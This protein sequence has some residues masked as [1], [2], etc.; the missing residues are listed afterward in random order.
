[1]RYSYFP[2]CTLKTKGAELD[3]CGILAA[4]ALGVELEEIPDWQCCGGVYPLA[5]DEIAPRLSSVRALCAA[6][7]RGDRLVTLC[8][9]CYHVLKR[10]NRDMRIDP[11]I[12]QKVNCYLQ[13]PEPYTGQTEV[14]HYLEVLRGL[15][16][17]PGEGGQAS[18][19][20]KGRRLLR[21]SAAA[22]QPGAGL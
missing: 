8:S 7:E 4:R 18:D 21:L 20:Q 10:V 15:G 13:L 9:A 22:P 11:E 1:M 3:R 17:P 2:G 5:R 19:R 14:V 6:R 12:R 16:D